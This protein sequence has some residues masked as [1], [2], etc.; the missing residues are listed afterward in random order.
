MLFSPRVR[1]EDSSRRYSHH[2]SRRKVPASY[3][4]STHRRSPTSTIFLPFTTQVVH[5]T[6]S[7]EYPYCAFLGLLLLLLLT[8]KRHCSIRVSSSF[9]C[10]CP[11]S[12]HLGAL[13]S[14]PQPQLAI[15][16]K[17]RYQRYKPQGKGKSPLLHQSFRLRTLVGR[18]G[19]LYHP[20]LPRRLQLSSR[21]PPE[22]VIVQ[23]LR[24]S[25]RHRGTIRKAPLVPQ[26][27]QQAADKARTVSSRGPEQ[28][29]VAPAVATG[30]PGR[31]SR[32]PLWL[33][34]GRAVDSPCLC[35]ATVCSFW[36]I[37]PII[38]PP[39]VASP[40]CGTKRVNYTSASCQVFSL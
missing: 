14:H 40:F 21:A 17:K 26:P 7:C 6:S 33:A 18:K 13:R 29:K 27:A 2:I 31:L 4:T 3:A 5:P 37:T 19:P 22:A 10:S 20:P 8:L 28:A 34:S 24:H 38:E 23:K 9:S 36:W 25:E 12:P 39:P 30:Y 16:K 35:S 32:G 11:L 1:R 15:D